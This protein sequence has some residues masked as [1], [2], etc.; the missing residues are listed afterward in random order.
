[1]AW[2]WWFRYARVLPTL[3]ITN[4]AR[5]F[6]GQQTSGHGSILVLVADIDSDTRI[7]GTQV[8][9]SHF[10]WNTV[11]FGLLATFLN[12]FLQANEIMDTIH[13]IKVLLIL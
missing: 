5:T 7:L 8:I 1:M 12:E 13:L 2:L 10:L 3:A 4:L 6:A 9:E 11:Y